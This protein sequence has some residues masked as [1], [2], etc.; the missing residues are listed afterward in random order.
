VHVRERERERERGKK[1]RKN[2]GESFKFLFPVI[3]THQLRTKFLFFS[4]GCSNPATT[5][6]GD[7]CVQFFSN[8]AIDPTKPGA[9]E[10]LFFFVTDKA[11]AFLHGM[12]EL[13][14]TVTTRA[15]PKQIYKGIIRC[16]TFK[17]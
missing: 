13:K 14:L 7:N 3:K 12:V 17:S 8:A 16:F 4:P 10:N 5:V 15:R 9:N 2:P 11:R 6:V 1:E